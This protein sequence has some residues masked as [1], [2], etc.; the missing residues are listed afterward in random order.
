MV[1]MV[2]ISLLEAVIN[3]TI[4]MTTTSCKWVESASHYFVVIVIAAPI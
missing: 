2:F 1:P 3:K 4:F